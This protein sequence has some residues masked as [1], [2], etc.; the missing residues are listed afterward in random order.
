MANKSSRTYKGH[1][2][3]LNPNRKP[4]AKVGDPSFYW[5]VDGTGVYKTLT[6]A[7][8]AINDEIA[9]DR[10]HKWSMARKRKGGK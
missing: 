7:K 1:H 10:I 5:K 2:I 4:G 8:K 3:Y 6:L 9:R